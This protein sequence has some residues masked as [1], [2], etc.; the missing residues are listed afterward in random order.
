MKATKKMIMIPEME[1]L[2]LLNMLKNR[3]ETG[4]EKAKLDTKIANILYD[5]KLNSLIKGKKYDWLV[6]QQQQIKKDIISKATKPQNVILD[7]E[8]LESIVSGI[9]KYL[10]I[11]PTRIKHEEILRKTIKQ[12]PLKIPKKEEDDEEEE[13][14]ESADETIRPYTKKDYIIHPNYY[15]D[16]KKILKQNSSK[17]KI[18]KAGHILDDK[19]KVIEGSNYLD[20]L[21]HLTGQE[22]TKPPGTDLLLNRMKGEKYYQKALNW[23]E[24]HRQKGEGKKIQM[25]KSTKGLVRKKQKKRSFKPIMWTKL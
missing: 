25:Y 5:P 10:G 24:S 8:Q 1:Y 13:E 3:D 19:D 20:I 23:A 16:M 11:E 7:N 9:S 15:E 14:F 21:E 18:D 17:L 4:Y 2:T 12:S 22:Y 6:K